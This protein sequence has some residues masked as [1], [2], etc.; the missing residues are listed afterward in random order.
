M[1]RWTLAVAAILMLCAS[2]S[3]GQG[4]VASISYYGPPSYPD[5]PP[6]TTVCN[7]SI[8]VPDGRIVRIFQDRNPVGPDPTDLQPVVCNNP[9][10]CEDGPQGTVN[11][12]QFTMNGVSSGLGAGYFAPSR[13]FVSVGG[14]PPGSRNYYLRIYE[15]DGITV[16]WTSSTFTLFSGFQEINLIFEEWTCGQG[17][18]QCLVVDETE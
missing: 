9:P 17:G 10:A 8:P 2:A 5:S 18:V 6:L 7:G 13:A 11:F 14:M 1:T 15:P 3:F 16:L 12:N 4:F